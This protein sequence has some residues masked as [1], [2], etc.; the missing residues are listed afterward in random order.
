MV[1]S[2]IYVGAQW[3]ISEKV[4][5]GAAYE[6][7]DNGAVAMGRAGAFA[8]KADDGTAIYYNPAGLAIQATGVH[9]GASFMF[10]SRCFSRRIRS[11]A[12]L[13]ATRTTHGSAYAETFFQRT[14]ARAIVSWAMSSEICASPVLL[15]ARLYTLRP[16]KV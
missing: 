3:Q 14:S 5:L 15:K 13:P 4:N 1:L 7:P 8:A 9:V 10:A 6:F 16:Y 11:I 2:P 12:R